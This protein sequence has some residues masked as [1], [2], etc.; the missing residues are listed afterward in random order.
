MT[1]AATRRSY[2]IMSVDVEFAPG[3][4]ASPWPRIP[5]LEVDQYLWLDNGYRPP[6][7][8]KLCYSRSSLP[9]RFQVGERRVRVN[10]VKFQPEFFDEI[11]FG[12]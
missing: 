6:V 8:V 9:V 2:T 7:E 3:A 10:Y 11:L 5:S 12:S 4:A 1:L